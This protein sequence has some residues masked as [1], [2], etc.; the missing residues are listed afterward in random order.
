MAKSALPQV[1]QPMMSMLNLGYLFGKARLKVEEGIFSACLP[2]R[3]FFDK[4]LR[5]F[6]EK[7]AMF[8]KFEFS[9]KN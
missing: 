8:W 1:I 3:Y 9:A 5:T 7:P 6:S 4:N 2:A